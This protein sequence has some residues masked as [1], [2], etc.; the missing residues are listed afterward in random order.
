M[1][2]FKNRVF[3]NLFAL[4][5]YTSI[6]S[7]YEIF[8]IFFLW[9]KSGM[10]RYSAFQ[11]AKCWQVVLH[12]VQGTWTISAYIFQQKQKLISKWS[13]LE[14]LGHCVKPM[15]GKL[16]LLLT[17]CIFVL[18]FTTLINFQSPSGKCIQPLPCNGRIP[19]PFYPIH[20]AHLILV[21]KYHHCYLLHN[22]K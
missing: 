2:P 9:N 19:I 1:I 17:T 18:T 5:R 15:Y 21:M 3:F 8:S 13:A 7:G 11:Q 14:D 12:F 22:V 10:S 16:G 20:Q 4:R 6:N